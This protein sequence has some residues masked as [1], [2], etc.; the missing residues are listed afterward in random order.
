MAEKKEESKKEIPKEIPKK[1]ITKEDK[2][3]VCNGLTTDQ[4][5]EMTDLEMGLQA[6]KD[7]KGIK[8]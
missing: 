7:L 2:E 8:T 3:I 5:D 4:M 1:K 6:Y